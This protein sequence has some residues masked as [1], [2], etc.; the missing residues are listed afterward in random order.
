[1]D[2]WEQRYR[3]GTTPWDRQAPS[4]A[5]CAWIADGTLTEGRILVP[6]C[7]RGHEVVELARHG[8][9]VT[10]IDIAPSAVRDARQAL[11]TLPAAVLEANILEWQAPATFDAVY[12][13]T[14]LCTLPPKL[15]P[16]YEAQLHKWLRPGG[17]LLAAFVQTGQEGGPPYHCGLDEMRSLFAADR[18]DWPSTAPWTIPHPIGFHEL[19][20]PLTR[21]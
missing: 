5:L 20:V 16:G 1:M 13:Q 9:E 8:F 19:A 15:W 17:M 2:F 7:G 11:G 6:G 21:R 14:C 3:E 10:G 4:P 12:E 18:W